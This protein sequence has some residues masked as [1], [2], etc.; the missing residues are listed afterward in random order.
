LSRDLILSSQSRR[1]IDAVCSV[2]GVEFGEVLS[3]N[4]RYKVVEARH[5]LIYVMWC[6]K[7]DSIDISQVLQCDRTSVI[8]AVDSIRER[9]KNEPMISTLHFGVMSKLN[10]EDECEMLDVLREANGIV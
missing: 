4:R 10:Q 1:Y 9:L 2:T 3:G 8:Y 6:S 7:Y 5:L